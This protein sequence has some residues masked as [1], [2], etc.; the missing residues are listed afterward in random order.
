MSSSSFSTVNPATGEQIEAFSSFTAGETE[1]T[2]ARAEKSFQSYRKLSVHQ[3]AQ[4]LSNLAA[5]LRKNKTKL[6]KIITTEMGKILSEAEAELEKCAWE[7]CHHRKAW[8]R[9][10]HAAPY[11]AARFRTLSWHAGSPGP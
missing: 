1:A 8:P 3:R 11:G 4:L 2:L 10:L 6:A 5:A 7:V 9:L